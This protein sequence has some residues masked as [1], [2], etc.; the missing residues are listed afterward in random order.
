MGKGK[1]LNGYV[2]LND[3]KCH[4]VH[5]SQE[6]EPYGTC[7]CG[8]CAAPGQCQYG[9]CRN[10]LPH[11]GAGTLCLEC[12]KDAFKVNLAGHSASIVPQVG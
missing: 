9:S 12:S 4:D 8:T 2:K 3:G 1:W 10:V 5:L 6:C 11:E 7:A